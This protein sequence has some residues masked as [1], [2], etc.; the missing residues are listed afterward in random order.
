MQPLFTTPP[1]RGLFVFGCAL[2]ILGA[3]WFSKLTRFKY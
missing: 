1:G 3:F 2:W